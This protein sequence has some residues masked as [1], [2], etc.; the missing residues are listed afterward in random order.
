VSLSNAR[1]E[2]TP[3]QSYYKLADV[4]CLGKTPIEYN[5][6]TTRT[7]KLPAFTLRFGSKLDI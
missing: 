4:K 7:L 2:Q 5:L 1:I 3:T 6:G